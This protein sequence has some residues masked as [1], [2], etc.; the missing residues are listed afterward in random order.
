MEVFRTI[1][2]LRERT[3]AARHVKFPP[4]P[5]VFS[6]S[7][8][9]AATPLLFGPDWTGRY[10]GRLADVV[11]ESSITRRTLKV[12]V[13]G[14][15][16]HAF[17]ELKDK[18]LRADV[19]LWIRFGTRFELG[20]GPIEAAVIA[21]PGRYVSSQ[22]RL[23]VRRFEAIP[24]IRRAQR[25]FRFENLESMLTAGTPRQGHAAMG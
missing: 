23:D 11:V 15:G 10:G 25:V 5:S 13:K 24:G 21:D 2:R 9:I 1:R 3:F 18:D 19:L 16:Q 8:A 6:E 12:E 20:S 7:I 22:R 17:Q 14:T 4:L